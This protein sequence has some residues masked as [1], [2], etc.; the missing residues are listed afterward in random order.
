[1]G[2]GRRT[3][4]AAG[5][6]I[7][8]MVAIAGPAGAAD[9]HPAHVGAECGEGEFL[10]MHFVN[11]QNSE[12]RSSRLDGARARDPGCKQ[13]GWPNGPWAIQG[14]KQGPA[15]LARC[16]APPW[17]HETGRSLDRPAGQAPPLR[18]DLLPRPARRGLG[19]QGKTIQAMEARPARGGPLRLSRC[20]SGERLGSLDAMDAGGTMGSGGRAVRAKWATSGATRQGGVLP[21]VN[22][23]SSRS[24]LVRCS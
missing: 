4:T 7:A 5:L 22:A 3:A 1:M 6:A 23:Y 13:P 24:P 19:S 17:R 11:N 14:E 9:L 20:G 12:G 16:H 10:A 15:L 18:L 2:N 8:A 21:C